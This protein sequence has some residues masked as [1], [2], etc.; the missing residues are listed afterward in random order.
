MDLSVWGKTCR[1][2]Q[3]LLLL[4]A[5]ARTNPG[6]DVWSFGTE[7]GLTLA[8]ISAVSTTLPINH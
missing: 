2:S 7:T 3:T 5:S 4:G 6:G 1:A 8:A